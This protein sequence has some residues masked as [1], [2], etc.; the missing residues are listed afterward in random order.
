MARGHYQGEKTMG[1]VLQAGLWWQALYKDAAKFVKK[2]NECQ[3]VK[4]LT[5][6]DEMPL[7]P[8]LPRAPFEKWAIDFIGPFLI[9]ARWTQAQYMIIAT[10]YIT[11]W[12]KATLVRDCT[13]KIVAKFLYE[14]IITWF[15]C[16]I[17][18]VSDQGTHFL[19]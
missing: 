4:R 9:Q 19:N 7:Q 14:N 3:R 17:Q 2:C 8:V 1:K 10:Y 13:T 5:K 15:G 11:K 16:P 18:I 12:A 6:R